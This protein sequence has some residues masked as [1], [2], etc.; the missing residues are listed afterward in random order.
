MNDTIG[1]WPGGETKF[2]SM[3]V[4]EEEELSLQLIRVVEKAAIAAARTMGNGDRKESDHVATEAMRA[5]FE[6]VPIDGTI[7]IGEGERDEAPMLY[8]GE[9]VGP[10]SGNEGEY[11]AVD[12][13][14][15]PLEGTNLC[16]TGTPG[17]LAVLAASE[18]GG[19]LHAPDCY[20]EKII[21]GPACRGK[22]DLDLPV[23][24]N[25]K[26]IARALDR[27][28]DDLAIVVLN[29]PRHEKLIREIREAGARI[30]LIGD[31]DLSAG[32]S[33]AIRGTGVHAVMGIGG[34]PEGVISAAAMRCLHGEMLGRLVIDTPELEERVKRM[35]ITDPHRVYSSEDLAPGKTI[36]F[37]ATGVTGGLSGGGI[38]QGIRF[39]GEGCRSQTLVMTKASRK[40]R[41]V[42]SVHMELPPGP[43]G[44]RLY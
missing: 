40:V 23:S 30:R 43:R 39:F 41:F 26:R 1:L 27:D 28:V 29:R 38:L 21:V 15:D 13:A 10:G 19:L 16:A 22:V 17:A 20:M 42:D 24:E 7:V 31:G 8:I 18:K 5:A 25:L 2:G 9:K 11:R 37:A 4:Q 12:I 34:A 6:D 36:I 44:V 35:G 32:V 3:T 33:V 14:V